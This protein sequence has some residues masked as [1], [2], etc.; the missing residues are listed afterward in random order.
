MS[1]MYALI[2]KQTLKHI[3]D[4]KNIDNN[5]ITKKYN[6]NPLRFEKWLDPDSSVYPTIR[7]AKKISSLLHI[8]FAALYMDSADIKVPPLPNVKNRRIYNVNSI[9]DNNSL[10]IAVIDLLYER[11]FLLNADKS[12]KSNYP[13]FE[14]D[15]PLDNDIKM[16][17]ASIRSFFNLKIEDQFNFNSSRKFYLHLRNKIENKG[18]LIQ[19]FRDVPLD[20]TRGL[21]IYNKKIPI[22]GINEYDRYPAKSFTII[23][24]LVHLYKH[25]SSV[26]NSF[27]DD[28]GSQNEEIFCNAVA[29]ELLVPEQYLK[30]YIKYKDFHDYYNYN[31][32]LDIANHFSVS[33]EVVIRRL[34]FIHEID[35][36]E[37][38]YLK[39]ELALFYEKEKEENIIRSKQGVKKY[40]R[41]IAR[42]TLDNTSS[43]ICKLLYKGLQN[44]I[45]SKVD[46]A[47][48]LGVSQKNVE[49]ILKEVSKWNN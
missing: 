47:S 13:F 2:N 35:I 16:W 38:K 37:Y 24:E 20:N 8:P 27:I 46:I 9:L 48:Y 19:G 11:D 7:Q 18:V 40:R 28:N 1:Y 5:Y 39:N 42:E 44:D 17:A 29:G 15:V 34:L 25:E 36:N 45:Y 43:N 31:N 26:C 49:A 33:K 4:R 21:S 12:I 30:K 23:H 6:F 22:I 32:I 3:I 41:N 14:P 10:N